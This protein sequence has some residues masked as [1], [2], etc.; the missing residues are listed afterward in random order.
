MFS[1]NQQKKLDFCIDSQ[2][3]SIIY[4]A[5]RLNKRDFMN[6]NEIRPRTS[7]FKSADSRRKLSFKKN[8]N[9]FNQTVNH[10]KT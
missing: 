6:K 2:G 8:N 7:S 9:K 1:I 10:F 3:I 4:L 5:C